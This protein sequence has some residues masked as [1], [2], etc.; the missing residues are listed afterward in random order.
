[1]ETF[2]KTDKEIKDQIIH[3]FL[4]YH[5]KTIDHFNGQEEFTLFDKLFSDEQ[6]V[7]NAL[8]IDTELP[9]L[10]LKKDSGNIV[11]CTTRRFIY[12]EKDS[13]Q[14]LT[15]SEFKNHT[16][17][18]SIDV[19]RNSRLH[20]GVKTDGYIAEFGLRKKDGQIV[21]WKI[22]TG[23]SGFA[24]WNVTKKFELIGRKYIIGEVE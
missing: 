20:I 12:L 9:V 14:A 16:G 23:K 2:Q 10:V 3:W 13:I 6:T 5:G 18:E 24:F 17:Y 7:I 15:Y 8:S 4:V 22:P 21:Y 11:I 1:M 19:Y